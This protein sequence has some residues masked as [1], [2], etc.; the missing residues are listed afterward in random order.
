MIAAATA[1]TD[2]AGGAVAVAGVKGGA[3]GDICGRLATFAFGAA[4]GTGATGDI[5]SIVHNPTGFSNCQL[6][7]P[8]V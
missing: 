5:L 8:S 2:S 4:P 7:R 6:E 1:A 3:A